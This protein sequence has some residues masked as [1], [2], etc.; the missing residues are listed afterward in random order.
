MAG[1]SALN[2]SSPNANST[3]DSTYNAAA[4]AAICKV[5]YHSALGNVSLW[6]NGSVSSVDVS[7]KVQNA[8]L[9]KDVLDIETLED[10]ISNSYHAEGDGS[11]LDLT[12]TFFGVNP[13]TMADVIKAGLSDSNTLNANALKLSVTRA[14]NL[15]FAL[16]I[17]KALLGG[18]EL[19]PGNE[20]VAPNRTMATNSETLVALAVSQGFALTS[21]LL[22]GCATAAAIF[23]LVVYFR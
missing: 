5:D 3:T 15:I 13:V 22:L 7:G 21:E 20:T 16:S 6:K 19:G 14:Y 12:Q 1:F 23:N 10:S 17:N 8:T 18:R 9:T 4:I 11:S 2:L